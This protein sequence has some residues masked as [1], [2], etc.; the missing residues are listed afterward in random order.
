MICEICK[1]KICGKGYCCVGLREYAH[2]MCLDKELEL[3]NLSDNCEI[4]A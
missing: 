2:N 4:K 3:K 1:S